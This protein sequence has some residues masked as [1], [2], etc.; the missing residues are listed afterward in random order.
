M[1]AAA[2]PFWQLWMPQFVLGIVGGGFSIIPIFIYLGRL[3][4]AASVGPGGRQPG[5]TR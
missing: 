4:R 3:R 2:A 5:E 1:S